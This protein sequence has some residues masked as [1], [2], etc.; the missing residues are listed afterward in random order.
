MAFQS[1]LEIWLAPIGNA[2]IGDE[3]VRQFS[4]EGGDTFAFTP[5]GSAL[6][7]S[8]GNRVWRQPVNGGSRQEIPVR[9]ILER[10]LP[11]PL[12][13]RHV[14]VLDF[15]AVG[16]SRATS[17]FIERG[18]M[19]W[20][21]SEQDLPPETVIVDADGRFAIPGLFDLHVHTPLGG[22]SEDAYLGYGI[23]SIRDV[24]GWLAWL[25]ALADRSEASGDPVPRYFFSGAFSVQ[26]VPAQGD[27]YIRLMLEGD[28][29]ARSYVRRL[30]E[31]GVSF[32]KVH[33][34][35]SWPLQRAVAEEV[36][37]LNMPGVGH[38][39][40]HGEI[41]SSVRRGDWTVEDLRNVH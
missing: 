17:V 16:F 29:E 35:I 32:I 22:A 23:T 24:G 31:A 25:N 26:A 40:C 3:D 41:S 13:L 1:N 15:D 28:E 8:A 18:R 37:R 7:Y 30:K 19:E 5:D 6:I 39:G 10:P 21:G 11:P 9:L 14:R 34:P 36:R 12:L 27:H 4:P 20:I 2:P 38:G 33:P